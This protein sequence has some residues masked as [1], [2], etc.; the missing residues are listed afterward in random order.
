MPR[1]YLLSKELYHCTLRVPKDEAFFVY[2]IFEASEGL[3]FYS[4][5]DESLKGQYRDL[6]VKCPIELKSELLQLISELQKSIRLDVLSESIIQD[7]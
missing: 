2:F 6:D 1:T 3:C 4:T 7:S 5:L